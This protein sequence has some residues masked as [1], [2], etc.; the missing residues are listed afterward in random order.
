[1]TA[2]FQDLSST[3]RKSFRLA[4]EASGNRPLAVVLVLTALQAILQ[5]LAIA[6]IMPFL[7]MAISPERTATLPFFG[8]QAPERAVLNL[9]ITVFVL[10]VAAAL[11]GMVGDTMRNYFAHFSAHRLTTNLLTRYANRPYAFHLATN[12]SLLLKKLRDDVHSWLA[13]VLLPLLDLVARVATAILLL[14][15]LV[16]LNPVVALVVFAAVLLIYAAILLGLRGFLA[17]ASARRD[18]LL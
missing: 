4:V 1:M 16:W 10:Q 6:S 11:F 13:F 12:S 18:H 15:L 8:G 3:V 7:T 9:G 17:R 14:A 5:M 2:F